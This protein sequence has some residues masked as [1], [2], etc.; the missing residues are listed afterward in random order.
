MLCSAKFLLIQDRLGRPLDETLRN[1]KAARVPAPAI[2]RLLAQETGVKVTGQT[3][4]EWT[5]ALNG[6]EADVA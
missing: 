3:I 4:R 6:H 5:R 2:A 1:F